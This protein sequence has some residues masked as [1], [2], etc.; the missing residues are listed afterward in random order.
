M[1]KYVI[2]GL[3]AILGVSAYCEQAPTATEATNFPVKASIIMLKIPDYT[4]PG[5]EAITTNCYFLVGPSGETILIDP[6]DQL[7]MVPDKKMLVDQKTGIAT[8]VDVTDLVKMTP[9]RNHVVT[10][11][12][13][14]Q[15]RLVYDQFHTTGVGPK[16]ILKVLKEKHLT[17]KIIVISHGHLDHFGG[18]TAVKAAT[19]AQVL[20]YG[21]DLRGLDGAILHQ[22][23]DK[24][25]VGYPKD[26]YRM[27]GVQT[28]VDR[29]LKENDLIS[30]DGMVWRV[31]YTPGHC[32]SCLDLVARREGDTPFDSLDVIQPDGSEAMSKLPPGKTIL[33]SG[34]TLLHW[35]YMLDLFGERAKDEHGEFIT[36]DTGRTDFLDGSGD[37]DQLY[38][39]I[40]DKLLILPEDTL[41]FP[42]HNDPT[43]IGEE[44]KYSPA[45]FVKDK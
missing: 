15:E 23:G 28:T 5:T 37:E 6:A 40:H 26:S 30:L 17:L 24:P 25:L 43:T 44:K 13:T 9:V 36:S 29:L 35:G 7:D 16:M 20:M 14:G 18:V 45:R 42:G 3:L 10:D 34:D 32:P 12:K 38:R 2:C 4:M 11:P 39:M 27:I 33:M 22:D 41:V 21:V 31:L 1:L 19:G 8:V